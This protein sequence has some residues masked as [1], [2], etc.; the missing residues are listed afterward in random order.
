MGK[1]KEAGTLLGPP[2]SYWGYTVSKLDHVS[3][4]LGIPRG[5]KKG[6]A[7]FNHVRGLREGIKNQETCI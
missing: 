3:N 7:Q 5:L 4:I 1:L 2:V 6:L